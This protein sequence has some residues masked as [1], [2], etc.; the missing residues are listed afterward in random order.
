MS[1]E[2]DVSAQQ[3]GAEAAAW[4]FAA[5]EYEERAPGAASANAEAAVAHLGVAME[6]CLDVTV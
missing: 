3:S 5:Y 2:A 1:H 6:I 4:V